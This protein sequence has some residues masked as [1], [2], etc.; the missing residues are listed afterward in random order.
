MGSNISEGKV[1]VF[2]DPAYPHIVSQVAFTQLLPCEFQMTDASDLSKKLEAGCRL[3]V[4]FH[5]PYFPKQAWTAIHR[6][7]EH[8][9]SIAIFGGMPFSRPV[10]EDGY[11]EPEQDAYSRQ[12]YLGPF[13]QIEYDAARSYPFV[14]AK[15]ASFL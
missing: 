15:A 12:L 4:S 13:F 2:H 11:I 9:G 14:S 3:L 1:L 10:R 8:G 5:G 7:L 6:F